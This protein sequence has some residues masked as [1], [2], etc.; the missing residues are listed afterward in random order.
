MQKPWQHWVERD[1]N[2]FLFGH[3][4]HAGAE[5]APVSRLVVTGRELAQAAGCEAEKVFEVERGFVAVVRRSPNQFNLRFQGVSVATTSF[6]EPPP[7][8]LYLLFSCYIASGNE[9]VISV[10]DF[11]RRMAK[12][13][14]HPPGTNYPLEGL[15]VLWQNFERWLVRA[16]AAGYAYREL[17]LPEPDWRTRIGYSLRLAFPQRRDQILLNSIIPAEGFAAQP[18]IPALIRLLGRHLDKFSES[19]IKAYE[20]FRRAFLDGCDDFGWSPL[21]EAVREAMLQEPQFARPE[22]CPDLLVTGEP[23]EKGRLSLTLL[24]DRGKLPARSCDLV[25]FETDFG[26]GTYRFVLGFKSPDNKGADAVI[27]FLLSNQLADMLPGFTSSPLRHLATEGVLIFYRG[28]SGILECRFNLELE[29]KVHVVVRRDLCAAFEQALAS[30]T[31]LGP[32]GIASAYN[33]WFEFGGIQA[34]LLRSISWSNYSGL[35]DV[36]C[37]QRCAATSRITFVGGI[38]TGETQTFF[39]HPAVLPAVRV[40]SGCNLVTM[41]RVSKIQPE[42]ELNPDGDGLFQIPV[43]YGSE[44]LEGEY[45]INARLA[46]GSSRIIRRNLR[47][48]AFVDCYDYVCPSQPQK[49][50]CESVR[51][52]MAAWN[53]GVLFGG[54]L[55][56][57]SNEK[58]RTV[59]SAVSPRYSSNNPNEIALTEICAAIGTRRCGFTESELVELFGAVLKITRAS[60]IRLVLRAWVEAGHLDEAIEASWRARRYFPRNPRLVLHSKGSEVLARV[61]GLSPAVLI[62]R[63]RAEVEHLGGTLVQCSSLSQ[64]IN[65]PWEVRGLGT[66]QLCNSQES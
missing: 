61:V 17:L 24:T 41:T 14:G 48:R 13:L 35:D 57:V 63:L 54:A 66:A 19:F 34:S 55:A 1:W 18:P 2:N 29:G 60:L 42:F 47:F 56:D 33:G 4:F 23:D 45:V 46:D 21:L 16:R 64:W 37:L 62:S 40:R 11:R 58:Q 32:H 8:V 15:G 65:G 43:G 22:D 39:G 38:A 36:R 3:Y 59:S 7:V 53:A 44:P 20:E 28:A 31:A 50:L 26:F 49:W 12:V 6:K 5:D 10:G 9:Q 52:D 51:A 25:T 27:E 30:A